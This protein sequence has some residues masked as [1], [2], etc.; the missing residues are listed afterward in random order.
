MTITCDIKFKKRETLTMAKAVLKLL[1]L[2]TLKVEKY[3]NQ[4]EADL[5]VLRYMI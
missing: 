3:Q 5:K 4:N 1:N 2:V